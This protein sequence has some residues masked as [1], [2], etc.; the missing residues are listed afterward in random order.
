MNDDLNSL[1]TIVLKEEALSKKLSVIDHA[2]SPQVQFFLRDK[3]SRSEKIGDLLNQI[4]QSARKLKSNNELNQ[5]LLEDAL[6]I[7]QLTLNL[8]LPETKENLTVYGSEGKVIADRKKT[9]V[10]D[11]KG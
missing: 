11:Y 1:E 9:Q 8:L 6:G 4:R 5:G 10:L 3:N 7:T 2:C